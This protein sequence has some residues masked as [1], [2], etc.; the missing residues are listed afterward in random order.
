MK[1]IEPKDIQLYKKKKREREKKRLKGRDKGN[2]ERVAF[3]YDVDD[4]NI[5]DF[6]VL[7]DNFS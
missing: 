3:G 2:E 5:Y 6:N 1:W 4:R 7:I